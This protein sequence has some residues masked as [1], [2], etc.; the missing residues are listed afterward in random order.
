VHDQFDL[1]MTDPEL[2]AEL[3]LC[4]DLMVAANASDT[5]LSLETI[6]CILKDAPADDA[7]PRPASGVVPPPRRG[8]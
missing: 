6:D 8:E 3:E 2:I 5:A 4:A 1:S 7:E